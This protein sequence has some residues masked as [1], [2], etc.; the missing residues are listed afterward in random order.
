MQSAFLIMLGKFDVTDFMISYPILGPMIFSAYNITI[1]YFVLNIFV[2]I[3]TDAFDRIRNEDK[4]KPNDFDLLDLISKKLFK[5]GSIQE[6]P[7]NYDQYRDFLS[8]FPRT[9][10]RLI[11]HVIKV[12][13]FKFL[14]S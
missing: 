3:I 11:N 12:I 6:N 1:L 9:V 8:I 4:K 2:S 7:I 14:I 13:Y 10:Q 5:K